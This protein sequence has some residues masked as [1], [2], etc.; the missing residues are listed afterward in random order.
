MMIDVMRVTM[1]W[2]VLNR[3]GMKSRRTAKTVGPRVTM[4][5]R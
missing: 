1:R 2:T 3:M 4:E 5:R